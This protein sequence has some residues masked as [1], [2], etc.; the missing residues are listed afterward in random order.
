MPGFDYRA[1]ENVG[2]IRVFIVSKNLIPAEFSPPPLFVHS[3]RIVGG[4]ETNVNTN[5][6]LS[7]LPPA[8]FPSFFL[9][10]FNSLAQ[11]RRKKIITGLFSLA[12]FRK[13]HVPSPFIP[14]RHPLFVAFESREILKDTV[15]PSPALETELEL[16]QDLFGYVARIISPL[17]LE[18]TSRTIRNIVAIRGI[19]LRIKNFRICKIHPNYLSWDKLKQFLDIYPLIVQ[20]LSKTKSRLNKRR[21]TESRQL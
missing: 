21:L 3:S 17:L 4:Q 6:F 18:E 9:E 12:S 15:R 1:F 20:L 13:I 8:N 10:F 19:V 5:A 2:K 16:F 14:L 11:D 7:S